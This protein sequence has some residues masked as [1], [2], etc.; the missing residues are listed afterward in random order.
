MQLWLNTLADTR[1]YRGIQSTK[2]TVTISLSPKSINGA[3]Q[4]VTKVTSDQSTKSTNIATNKLF[5]TRRNT[6]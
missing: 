2:S 6:H 3:N 1:V 4:R 5:V